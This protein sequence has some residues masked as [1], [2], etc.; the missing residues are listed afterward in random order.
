MEHKTHAATEAIQGFKAQCDFGDEA[1]LAL[2]L[3]RPVDL[4]KLLARKDQLLEELATVQDR[5]CHVRNLVAQ[6][7]P[8]AE[9]LVRKVSEI[10]DEDR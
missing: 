8:A 1:E 5:G 10:A 3:M 7:D 4:W 2:R 9:A 6:L